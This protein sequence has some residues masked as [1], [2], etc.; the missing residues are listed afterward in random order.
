MRVCGALKIAARYRAAASRSCRWRR[1]A[2]NALAHGLASAKLVL[3]GY[4]H[5]IAVYDAAKCLRKIQGAKPH[6]H[7]LGMH[8]STV[9]NQRLID[10]KGA[11]WHEQRVLM[12]ARDD[13]HLARH[14]DHQIVR[15]LFH[16]KHDGV[17]LS[18]W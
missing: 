6:A 5:V 14:S 17:A 1:Q 2:Y 7:R 18:G 11:R 15:R 12:N 10:Q 8:N 9:H 16:L 4:D 3:V 13:V